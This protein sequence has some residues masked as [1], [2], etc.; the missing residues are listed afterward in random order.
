MEHNIVENKVQN[1]VVSGKLKSTAGIIAIVGI[2]LAAIGFFTTDGQ[3]VATRFWSSLL[4]ND[5]FFTWIAICAGF[6]ICAFKL[7]YSGWHTLIQRIPEAIGHFILIGL[8]LIFIIFI[9]GK[10]ELYEW[11]HKDIVANDGFLQAKSWWLNEPTFLIFTVIWIVTIIFSFFKFRQNSLALD[12]TGSYKVYNRS[13]ILAAIFLFFFAIMNSVSTWHWVMSVEPH[14]YSTLYAWYLFASALVSFIAVTVITLILLKRAG[15]LPQVNINHFHDLG[16][17]LFAFSIFWTYLWFSQFMLIWYANIPE[18]T[19]HFKY[20]L[21]NHGFLFFF[22]LIINFLV[23]LLVLMS[24]D[25]KRNL[26]TLLFIS[27]VILL[28]HWFDFFLMIRPG[29]EKL[30]THSIHADHSIVMGVGFME[31]GIAVTFVGLF[32]FVIALAL[33]KANLVP[34]NHPLERES[35]EHHI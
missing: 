32:I 4:Y 2:V 30:L 26:G 17:F 3:N 22:T 12:K 16:K 14:W 33:S 5:L 20:L 11:T 18:E 35:I 15:Y 25:A 9:F 23:P 28:G 1:F 13:F 34:L 29:T 8:P 19:I 7:G 31:L 24:R 21:Q 27:V 10:H 6:F